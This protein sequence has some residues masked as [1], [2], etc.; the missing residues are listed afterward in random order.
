MKNLI[1]FV[2]VLMLSII[3][4]YADVPPFELD[5]SKEG[6]QVVKVKGGFLGLETINKYYGFDIVDQYWGVNRA[7]G[8]VCYVKCI[9]KGV[10]RCK[11]FIDGE[12]IPLIL[13][14]TGVVIDKDAFN[15][16]LNELVEFSDL[17]ITEEILSLK[18]TKKISVATKD[19]KRKVLVF[20][21][22]Y[23]FSSIDKGN[24]KITLNILDI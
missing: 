22:D 3:C 6:G 17:A 10:T 15:S 8:R 1:C 24:I 14:N 7:G 20:N 12:F 16:I 13:S 4:L 2:S 5:V 19:G 11:A 18:R 23:I 21:A 9:G